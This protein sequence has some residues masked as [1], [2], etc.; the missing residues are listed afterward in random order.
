MELTAP[1][2]DLYRALSEPVRLRL[3]ALCA[4]EELSIGELAELTGESQPNV[5]RHVAALKQAGLVSLR[6]D[7][8]R[9]FIRVT[10]GISTDAVVADAIKSG[11]AL[12]EKDGSLGRLG[13][14][15][16]VRDRVAREYFASATKKNGAAKGAPSEYRAY[17]TLIASLLPRRALAVDIGTGDGS[18]L[19]VVAP[20]FERVVAVDRSEAQLAFAKERV[21]TRGYKNV[22]LVCSE[23]RGEKL[24]SVVGVGADVVFAVRVLHH[25]PSP[26]SVLTDLASLVRPGGTALVLDYAPH[27][28]ESMRDAAD[29]WLGFEPALLKKFAKVAGFDSSEVVSVPGTFRGEGPDAHLPWQALVAK[30]ASPKTK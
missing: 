4:E 3:L 18:L 21:R 15:L 27:E 9:S 20:M 12:C 2:W 10:S 30:K 5:S 6:K 1:R 28:D 29:L 14:V 26:Q 25:A 13:D 17:L 11:R 24:K 23:V 8:T 19:D 7:G 16:E 22:E